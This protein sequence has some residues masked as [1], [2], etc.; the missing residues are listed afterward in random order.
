MAS[1]ELSEAEIAKLNEDAAKVHNTPAGTVPG[2]K[3]RKWKCTSCG[4]VIETTDADPEH[5]GNKMELAE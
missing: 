1:E 5:C 4:E 2:I 3:N